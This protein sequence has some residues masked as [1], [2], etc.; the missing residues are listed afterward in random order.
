MI[1]PFE[2]MSDADL[3]SA[4]ADF[5]EYR[6]TKAISDDTLLGKARDMY[7]E[8]QGVSGIINLQADLLFACALRWKAVYDKKYENRRK[9]ESNGR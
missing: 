2:T 3:R 5:E 7:C 9:G 8:T 4:L 1:S 6:R